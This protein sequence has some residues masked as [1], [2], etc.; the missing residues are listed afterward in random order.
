MV[1]QTIDV[2]PIDDSA[3][4]LITAAEVDDKVAQIKSHAL[5]IS[6]LMAELFE[7]RAWLAVGLPDWESFV[8]DRFDRSGSWSR[9][10]ITALTVVRNI[11]LSPGETLPVKHAEQLAKLP[12]EAQAMG[13]ELAL[14]YVQNTG[15]R[16]T[17]TV[18]EHAVSVIEEV[19]E[20]GGAIAFD[21]E[22]VPVE[23]P[24]NLRTEAARV[25]LME[26]VLEAKRKRLDDLH[27]HSTKALLIAHG[28]IVQ[29]GRGRVLVEL[30]WNQ[31][32][33]FAKLQ[34]SEVEVTLIVKA[35]FHDTQPFTTATA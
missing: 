28:A 20:T 30:D 34:K 9:K 7:R 31:S 5:F 35:K 13:Y 26:R 24:L 33:E 6:T 25:A 3:V 27:R 10:M 15:E 22:S 8:K 12:A 4:V 32:E 1:E 29:A 2:Y 17:T 11:A 19:I 16:L 18:I 21:G 23:A 14:D